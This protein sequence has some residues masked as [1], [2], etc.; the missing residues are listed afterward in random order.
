[1]I[2]SFS[3]AAEEPSPTSAPPSNAVLELGTD[4]A[5][6]KSIDIYSINKLMWELG[7]Y[8]PSNPDDIN[9]FMRVAE[10]PLFQKFY[11]DDITWEKIKK[12][13]TAYLA[14]KQE[15]SWRYE[16][17]FPAKLGRYDE[18]LNG[19]PL[20]EETDLLAVKSVEVAN[21]LG[22]DSQNA[23]MRREYG[24]LRFPS[25]LIL[26]VK[27]PLTLSFIRVSKPVAEAY[28]DRLQMEGIN[29]RPIYLRLRFVVTNL[30]SVRG[31]E[32]S[33]MGVALRGKVERVDAFADQELML[34]IFGQ[35][36]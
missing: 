26:K 12:S 33:D 9:T 13:M 20:V 29:G 16:Y 19:F 34:P 17:T 8:S 21:F 22:N 30:D 14:K 27:S 2:P 36:F 23:C 24:P 1:M 31:A 3:L 11:N 35:D 15:V 10:C 18:N 5:Q 6:Y 28:L 25:S 4:D 7:V 32:L